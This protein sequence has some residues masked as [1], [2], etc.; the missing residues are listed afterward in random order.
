MPYLNEA[1]KRG[2]KLVV[3]DPRKNQIAHHADLH[4]PVWPGSDLVVALWLIGEI[5]RRGQVANDVPPGAHAERGPPARRGPARHD[6]RR[7]PRGPRRRRRTSR[8]SPTSTSQADPG[9][10]PDRVGPR[11]QPERR[12]RDGRDPR[13]P[14][15]SPGSSACAAAATRSRTRARTARRARRWSGPRCPIR[16]AAARST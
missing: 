6:R 15:R 5:E 7:G 3:I 9:A 2:A 1:R 13:D 16:R 12:R 8:A 4:L 14:G 10:H 11:A